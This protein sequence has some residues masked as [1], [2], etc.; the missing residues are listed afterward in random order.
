M[1]V[2]LTVLVDLLAFFVWP[3]SLQAESRDCFVLHD[4]VPTYLPRIDVVVFH[5]V[6]RPKFAARLLC[7]A[8][9]TEFAAHDNRAGPLSN[10]WKGCEDFWG[11]VSLHALI[12]QLVSICRTPQS[13]INAFA[14]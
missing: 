13:I 2:G 6:Q 4:F 8:G 7:P 11:R 1:I 10:L 5:I 9:H 14:N 12:E 3:I